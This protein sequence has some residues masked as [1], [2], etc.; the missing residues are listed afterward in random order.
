MVHDWPGYSTHP[1]MRMCATGHI[2]QKPQ[3]A[4]NILSSETPKKRTLYN[5][6]LMDRAVHKAGLKLT[7]CFQVKF[8]FIKSFSGKNQN[9][10]SRYMCPLLHER[11]DPRRVSPCLQKNR[12]MYWYGPYKARRD[13]IAPT[14]FGPPPFNSMDVGDISRGG[15]HGS[16]MGR[17]VHARRY[18]DDG[19]GQEWH[20][21]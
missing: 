3:Q 10:S 20:H 21:P 2:E 8:I 18:T 17:P 14:G 19:A 9:S 4:G 16:G 11:P 13:L 12:R 6:F 15:S 1:P 7:Y 5:I